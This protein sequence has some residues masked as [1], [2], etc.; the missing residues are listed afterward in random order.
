MIEILLQQVYNY[1]KIKFQIEKVGCD[2]MYMNL[3]DLTTEQINDQTT[4][5]DQLPTIEVLKLIN[6]EDKRVA[7][8]VTEVLPQ[9]AEA[10]ESV[11]QHL[12]SGGRLFYIGAGTSGRL[13][14]LDASE[15]PPTFRTAPEMVQGI[16][17]G[18]NG[19]M[20]TAVEGAEDN[21][22]MGSEDLKSRG[23]TSADIVV[24]IAASGR[25]PYVLGALRYAA[26]VG[27]GTISL[28][29]NKDSIISQHA[30]HK[31]E[32]V[33]GSE[34]LA[35]STRLKAATAQKM[36]LNMITTVTMIKLGKV[37]QNLMVDLN[38]SN[39]K[40]LER[41]RNIVVQATGCDY[42]TASSILVETNHEVKPGI[43]MIKT[44]ASYELVKE[45]IQ[46]SEGS[47]YKAIKLLNDRAGDQD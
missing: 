42:E 14:V 21:E 24:G 11:Y 5:I 1:F 31:I 7:N 8:A 4:Q 15:C 3:L 16:I 28:T 40:L 38:A 19:A 37:Y 30:E 9:V 17:A 25:T 18:G 26:Q 32:V 20:F 2:L 44:G 29:C 36:I 12:K 23:F 46:R 10:I 45:Y 34:I 35:G 6:E 43:V 13:G 41:A 33:V 22:E 47:V 39:Q 27:G